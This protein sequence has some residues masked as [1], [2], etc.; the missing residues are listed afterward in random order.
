MQPGPKRLNDRFRAEPTQE[1]M[2]LLAVRTRLDR[3]HVA[4]VLMIEQGGDSTLI[5]F[6]DVGIN[7]ELSADAFQVPEF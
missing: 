7:V 1:D 6:I 4:E 5:R 3:S 2:V